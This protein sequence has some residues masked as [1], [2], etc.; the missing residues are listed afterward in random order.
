MPTNKF[1]DRSRKIWL[2][3][4]KL[5]FIKDIWKMNEFAWFFAH[6]LPAEKIV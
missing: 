4:K 2:R 1:S 6:L 5:N 3:E